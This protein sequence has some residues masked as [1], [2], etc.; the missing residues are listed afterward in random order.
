M[1]ALGLWNAK[2]NV[3]SQRTT[4]AVP[5]ELDD[6]GTRPSTYSDDAL[7]QAF[8]RKYAN[9]LRYVPAWGWLQ[10]DNKRWR[11][12]P[13][14]AVMQLARVVCRDVAGNARNDMTLTPSLRE[15]LP[16]IIASAAAVAAVE[17]LA[18]GAPE[19]L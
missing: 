14:V 10:W 9:D 13:D 11:I 18:R 17:R 12:I 15:R 4:D 1:S 19:H 7:A 3:D 2:Q 6:D 5:E 16:R 8:S